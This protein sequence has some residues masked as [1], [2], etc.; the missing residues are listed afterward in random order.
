MRK[1][2][3]VSYLSLVVLTLIALVIPLGVVFASRE[4]DRLFRDVEHDAVVVGAL[5]EDAL[6]RGEP[7]DL[8]SLLADY[9]RDP[10][11]R[12]VVVD[13]SGRSVADSS[14][15]IGADF[16]NRPEIESA[17][18]GN[19]AEGTRRSETLGGDLVFVAV[20]VASGGVVHGAVR[21]TYP[22]TTLDE[23]VRA[24][25]LGLAG[26]SAVILT[27]VA[28][29]ASFLARSVTQPVEKLK[30][31]ARSVAAGDLSARA[32][33]DDGAPELREL[34]ETFNETAARLEQTLDAQSSFLAD[35]SHQLRTPLAALRL[36]LENIESAAP[37]SLQPAVAAAR[38]ETA[39]L[40]RIGDTLLTLTRAAS[41]TTPAACVDLVAIVRER[42]GV[43]GPLADDGGVRLELDVPDAAPVRA[44]PGA[45]E[46]VLDNLLDNALDVA[47]EGSQLEVRVVVGPEVTELHVV[48]AGRGLDPD[49][50]ARA[51]D[52]FWRGP[53]AAPGGTGLGLAIVAQLVA[54]SGGTVQLHGH[55]PQGT[56]VTVTLATDTF[57]L[58]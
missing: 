23:R 33:T 46:Q 36:Q 24:V 35:A 6:E 3:L 2:L 11:G 32:A 54:N 8:G 21:V 53:D 34:A 17:L 28:A 18:Q 57:T 29:L 5:S 45:L 43:W 39:R 50:R 58:R 49:Q 26:L 48:D 27:L 7:P 51:F 31:A 55:L 38:A 25:W 15:T 22:S 30:A 37:L 20:P 12:I 9:A 56:D 42:A 14:G 4:R 19:R 41:S 40:G 44:V 13:T 1:R 52:R 47:P 10:G 16:T